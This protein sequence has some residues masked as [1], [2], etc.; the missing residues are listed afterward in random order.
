MDVDGAFGGGG[1]NPVVALTGPL[2][3]SELSEDSFSL[4][5]LP[6]FTFA[7]FF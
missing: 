4:D 6:N 5:E 2:S 7:Y 3:E 1:L